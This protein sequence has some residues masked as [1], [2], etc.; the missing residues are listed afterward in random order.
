[1]IGVTSSKR[2]AVVPDIPT[3]AEAGVPRFE[4]VQW[5]GVLAPAGTPQDVIGKVHAAIV[6]TLQDA[7]VRDRF[8]SDG[9][10]PVGGTPEAFAEVIRADLKKWER[11]IRDLNIR[12]DGG[13]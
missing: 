7:S 9:A 6:R 5:F 8:V 4:V 3:I 11:V 12:L 10:E 13:G 2:A 1:A